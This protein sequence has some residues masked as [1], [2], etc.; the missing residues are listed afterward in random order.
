M[1]GRRWRR[2]LAVPR[3]RRRRHAVVT[4]AGV[5][6]LLAGGLATRVVRP[7]AAVRAVAGAAT[8]AWLAGTAEFAVARIRPGP[9]TA[10]EVA[11][12]VVTS[13]LIPPAATGHWLRGWLTSRGA[14][15]L[16]RSG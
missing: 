4:A 11:V 7:V 12:M 16:R 10:G 15:P 9:R 5:T 3:G 2:L 14:R 8:A 6:A 1:Y 13:I